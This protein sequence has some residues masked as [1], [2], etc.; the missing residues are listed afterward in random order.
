MNAKQGAQRVI[1]YNHAKPAFC[2]FH[3]SMKVFVRLYV[4]AE[5][6]GHC[7]FFSAPHAVL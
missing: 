5:T 7:G 6:A 4:G 2:G 3:L 1:S